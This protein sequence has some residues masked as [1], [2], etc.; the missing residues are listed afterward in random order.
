RELFGKLAKAF[1]HQEPTFALRPWMLQLARSG[2]GMLRP[3]S[4]RA[5]LI[6][7]HTVRSSLAR[8]SWSAARAEAELGLRFRSADEA[9]ANVAAFRGRP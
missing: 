5:P 9:V 8:R 3:F 7:R 4:S 2:T 6:T 1:G